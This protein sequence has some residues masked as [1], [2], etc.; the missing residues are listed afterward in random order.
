M[1]DLQGGERMASIAE[2]IAHPMHNGRV[3]MCYSQNPTIVDE[4]GERHPELNATVTI[5]VLCKY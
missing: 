3:Y 4:N 2:F 5:V 1:E